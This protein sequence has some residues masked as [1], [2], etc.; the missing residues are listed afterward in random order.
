MTRRTVLAGVAAV[1]GLLVLWWWFRPAPATVSVYFIRAEGAEGTLEPA[2]RTVTARGT[3]A[4]AEAALREL[5]AGPT[6]AERATG[7]TTAVPPGTR[8]RGVTVREGVVRADFD[9]MVE[10]GG[11]SASMLGRFWQIV[12]TATQFQSAP[13]VRILI[14]G[15]ERTAMGGE[16]VLID[17]PV[18]RPPTV[19][20]F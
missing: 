20:H 9:R 8:L 5:L 15:A 12:Y 11:G 7:L 3:A 1:A 13:R 18:A 2:T 4:L 6:G 10:A 16:G 14:E 19:P 17:R